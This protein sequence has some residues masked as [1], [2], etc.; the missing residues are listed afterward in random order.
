M[1]REIETRH[2]DEK[3]T[4]MLVVVEEMNCDEMQH[5]QDTC[6]TVFCNVN[7]YLL[8]NTEIG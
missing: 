3:K 7:L 1:K 5:M 8:Y 4:G 6:G 2:N